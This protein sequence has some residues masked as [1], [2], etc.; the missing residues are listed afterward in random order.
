MSLRY[1]GKDV[2]FPPLLFNVCFAAATNKCR[3]GRIRRGP[4]YFEGL[5]SPRGGPVGDGLA[6][7]PLACVRRSVGGVLYAEDAGIVSKS[8]EGLAK[9]MAVFVTVFE[10]ACLTVY[11]DRKQ[12]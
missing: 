9:M 12:K 2:I 8:A 5:G 4:R 1:R 10:A 11:T 7:E 6:V 3:L